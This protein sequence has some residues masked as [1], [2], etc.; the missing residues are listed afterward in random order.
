MWVRL[1]PRAPLSFQNVDVVPARPGFRQRAQTP[2]QRLKFDSHPGHQLSGLLTSAPLSYT[3][4]VTSNRGVSIS[5]VPVVRAPVARA[6]QATYDEN[7]KDSTVC[8]S[9]T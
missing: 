8:G 4:R 9:T 6:A 5:F 7:K 1:P 2:A 3:P